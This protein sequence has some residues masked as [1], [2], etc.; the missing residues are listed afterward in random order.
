MI[1]KKYLRK[2]L[3]LAYIKSNALVDVVVVDVLQK[4]KEVL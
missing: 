3:L 4:K 1:E 2:T